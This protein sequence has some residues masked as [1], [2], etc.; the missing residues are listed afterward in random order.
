M[1]IFVKSSHS[2]LLSYHFCSKLEFLRPTHAYYFFLG[3]N[4]AGHVEKTSTFLKI[5]LAAIAEAIQFADFLSLT[6]IIGHAFIC[7]NLF[8]I[9]TTRN[10]NFLY[11]DKRICCCWNV[12]KNGLEFCKRDIPKGSSKWWVK[13]L[14]K[15]SYFLDR[16]SPFMINPKVCKTVLLFPEHIQLI[17]FL[18]DLWK[19]WPQCKSQSHD[20][21]TIISMSH[22]DSKCVDS[23]FNLSWV[24]N[25]WQGAFKKTLLEIDFPSFFSTVNNLL[26][27]TFFSF[28]GFCLTLKGIYDGVDWHQTSF[29]FYNSR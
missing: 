14:C 25:F 15:W 7:S 26:N 5:G 28:Q 20:I 17:M 3:S 16:L 2:F 13:L 21:I 23:L 11:R 22:T 29:Q 18:D 1:F 6:V 8:Q 27:E 24:T 4:N 9:H 10:F 12:S 19:N